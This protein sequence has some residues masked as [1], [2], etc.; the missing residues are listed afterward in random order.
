MK[1][2]VYS[3]LFSDNK[4][5]LDEPLIKNDDRLEGW[6]YI[7]FTNVPNKVIDSGWV[8]INKELIN[9]HAVYTAKHYKWVAHKYL[10]DYDIAIYVDA[11]MSPSKMDWNA[12]INKL[13]A[14]DI[15]NGIILK[16]HMHRG[17]IYR[18]CHAIA[19]CRKDTKINM[20]KVINFL[21]DE[22]MPENYGLSEGG[23]FIRHL[24]NGPINILLEELFEL[25]LKFTYRDQAL[26][27]YIFWKHDLKLKSELTNEFYR[28]TGKIGHH[29]YV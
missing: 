11:Y 13:N 12:Y 16:K 4:R 29:F 14:D 20:D 27:S 2:V 3:C 7:I 10:E 8:P 28:I 18:E 23:L 17:C 22:K 1:K 25:M 21:K 15:D 9:N 6:D 26:L 5:R 19:H 24:K